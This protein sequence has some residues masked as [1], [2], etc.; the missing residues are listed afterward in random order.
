MR[1]LI[2]GGTTEA[3]ALARHLAGRGDF[4]PILSLAGR[5]QNPVAP[6]IPREAE[7]EDAL[8]EEEEEAD[9]IASVEGRQGYELEEEEDDETYKE[10]EEEEDEEA[11]FPDNQNNEEEF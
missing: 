2:L 9:D 5:T 7:S 4:D 11:S 10:D 8:P 1:L 6:P 3:S